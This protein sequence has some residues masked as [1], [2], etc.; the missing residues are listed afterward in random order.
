MMNK[1]FCHNCGST[2]VVATTIQDVTLRLTDLW[3]VC[4]A[5]CGEWLGTWD[6][7]KLNATQKVG[8]IEIAYH[9]RM[10]ENKP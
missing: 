10:A 6:G 8:D 7:E 3:R 2:Y 9:K 5:D 4:C 1:M